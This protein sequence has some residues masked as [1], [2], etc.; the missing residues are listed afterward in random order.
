MEKLRIQREL[1]TSVEGAQQVQSPEEEDPAGKSEREVAEGT[2]N[3]IE[4]LLSEAAH[5]DAEVKAKHDD[6]FTI[7]H[8]NP[9]TWGPTGESSGSPQPRT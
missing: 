5:Q 9:S 8:G 6:H 2:S 3:Y 4:T 7:F 1:K